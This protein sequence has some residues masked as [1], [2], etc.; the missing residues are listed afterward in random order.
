MWDLFFLSTALCIVILFVPTTVALRSLNFPWATSIACAPILSIVVYSVEAILFQKIG[1]WCSF[2]TLF[3]PMAIIATFSILISRFSGV[4]RADPHASDLRLLGMYVMFGLVVGLIYYVKPL[5]GPSCY[6]QAWDDFTH[7]ALIQSFIDTGVYSTLC[8]SV[9]SNICDMGSYYPAGWHLICAMVETALP[10]NNA[11]ASNAVNYVV[12]SV[13]YPSG[14][15]L[16]IQTLFPGKKEFHYAGIILS[17]SFVAFPWSFL[18]KGK[19]V[20]NMLGYSLIPATAALFIYTLQ[21][22]RISPGTL[23]NTMLT[24]IAIASA[25]FTQPNF[26]FSLMVMLLPFCI[27][28]ILHCNKLSREKAIIVAFLFAGVFC[29]VWFVLYK[30]PALQGTVAYNLQGSFSGK[31]AAVCDL[32]LISYSRTPPQP[33]LAALVIV[34]LISC[35]KSKRHRWLAVSYAIFSLMYVIDACTEGTLRHLLTGFWYSD[36]RRIAAALAIV[37]FPIAVYGL[38]SLIQLAKKAIGRPFNAKIRSIIAI[39][40]VIG[41]YSPNIPSNGV[42]QGEISTAFGNLKDCISVVFGQTSGLNQF[43]EPEE[44][45]FVKE[46]KELIGDALVEN[47]PADGS[48]FAYGFYGLNTV[49]R[50]LEDHGEIPNEDEIDATID[51]VSQSQS[52]RDAIYESGVEYVLQLDQGRQSPIEWPAYSD[53][54]H[55]P[56]VDAIRD[57][58]DGFSIVLEKEDMRLYRVNIN[59]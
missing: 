49:H 24:L 47:N 4:W 38:V 13:I 31:A 39:I 50:N 21:K 30:L 9:Y 32:L 54:I 43:F 6:S 59:N 42:A 45:E 14:C 55:V 40:V 16:L 3:A 23:R 37:S 34:G 44:Q 25:I 12:C 5:D 53:N 11:L 18:I 58:T 48:S 27:Y 20:S 10:T 19:V 57:D 8:T 46:V 33:I 17:V 51:K 28:F 22:F 41:I 2:A 36:A 1:I 15:M 35:L 26:I 56:G 7:Y 52:A 29:L